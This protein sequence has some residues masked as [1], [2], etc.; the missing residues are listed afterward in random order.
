MIFYFICIVKLGWVKTIYNRDK[1]V[2]SYL[3]QLLDSG[4]AGFNMKWQ[5]P[6]LS[7]RWDQGNVF[8]KSLIFLFECHEN[9]MDG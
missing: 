1:W 4:G 5:V 7:E 9:G 2:Y 8:V 3:H 6:K